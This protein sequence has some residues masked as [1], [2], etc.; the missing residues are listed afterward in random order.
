MDAFVF[1]LLYQSFVWNFIKS[2]GKVQVK[3]VRGF[4]LVYNFGQLVLKDYQVC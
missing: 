2:F 1:K 4:A 3:N